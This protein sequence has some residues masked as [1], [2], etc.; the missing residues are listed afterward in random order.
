MNSKN[1][2]S[3]NQEIDKKNNNIQNNECKDINDNEIPKIR[4]SY[5]ERFKDFRTFENNKKNEP[6][7]VN[8]SLV[9]NKKII[10]E[11]KEILLKDNIDKNNEKKNLIIDRRNKNNEKEIKIMNFSATR[12]RTNRDLKENKKEYQNK[13]NTDNKKE[14]EK[15]EVKIFEKSNEKEERQTNKKDKE[16]INEKSKETIKEKTKEIINEKIN[17]IINDKEVEK[18]ND[19]E[20]EI[21]NED[22]N[23][24]IIK[25]KKFQSES[26]KEKRMR[27]ARKYLQRGERSN[28][29]KQKEEKEKERSNKE[30]IKG[31][32]EEK[33][34]DKNKV[35]MNRNNK[36]IVKERNSS[37]E[38]VRN[39]FSIENLFGMK[40]QNKIENSKEKKIKNK[41]E[42]IKN[43]NSYNKKNLQKDINNEEEEEEQNNNNTLYNKRR[44]ILIRLKYKQG[45]NEMNMEEETMKNEEDNKKLEKTIDEG[46]KWKRKRKDMIPAKLKNKRSSFTFR[47]NTNILNINNQ[48]NKE[49][50]KSLG[51]INIENIIKNMNSETKKKKITILEDVLVEPIDTTKPV[52][53]LNLCQMFLKDN[54]NNNKEIKKSKNI[55]LFGFDKSNNDFIQFDLKKKKF[56]RI[57]I[58]EIEDISDS[59]EKEYIYQNTL[60]YNT[61]T[62]VFILTGENTDILYYYYPINETLTKLCKF[63]N[64]HSLGCLLLDHENNRLLIIGGKNT[65]IC[66][67]YSF[68]S[69][70]IKEL[71]NLNYDRCNASFIISNDRI[72]GFFG[73]SFKKGKY[74]FNIEYIDKNKLD[75]W[76]IIDLNFEQKKDL[77]PFHLKNISTFNYE[78]TP[79]KIMIYGGKQ[80]RNEAIVDN[81][82][83][84]YDTIEN[85]FEK[86]EGL[87]YNIIK[88]LKSINTWKIAELI[89]NEEKNGFFFDKQ[90]QFLEIPGEDKMQRINEN[91][92]A[93]IDSECN[94]HFLANNQ[95][96]FTVYKFVK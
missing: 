71:P 51:Q 73:F 69:K 25:G 21:K 29:I 23:E 67:S 12:N 44:N 3:Y 32:E 37:K 31:E 35:T 91:T 86:M 93:I 47:N 45:K 24:D 65:N 40:R 96:Y 72:Y 17:E 2:Y 87:F 33:L 4:N 76:E 7:K 85:K 58:P 18:T 1:K 50:N 49:D 82:Y 5:K 78:K 81:Y 10:N 16:K 19:K 38:K 79:N 26:E 39:F 95:K 55:F 84:I 36:K 54:I 22:D 46:D 64:G 52:V 14:K 83:Y 57:K 66:E 42:I 63:N 94:I 88:D 80:G 61:L 70:E 77:L 11:K 13:R 75:K 48:I 41:E 90:K 27:R 8:I 68:D 92:C 6:F 20:R 28:N 89:E 53:P 62:G 15:E 59:F 60:L 30:K 56:L 43:N 74:L 9:N 34:N